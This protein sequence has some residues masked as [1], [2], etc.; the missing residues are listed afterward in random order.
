MVKHDFDWEEFVRCKDV[1]W[2]CADCEQLFC[3]PDSTFYPPLGQE[4]AVS[5]QFKLDI[6]HWHNR[7]FSPGGWFPE[8]CNHTRD[9]GSCKDCWEKKKHEDRDSQKWSVLK[10]WHEKDLMR[11]AGLQAWLIQT[12]LLAH[13]RNLEIV[14][15]EQ[16]FNIE[17]PLF[18]I[19]KEERDAFADD[20]EKSEELIDLTFEALRKKDSKIWNEDSFTWGEV[21]F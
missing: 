10:T 14:L 2:W 4:M 7:F 13:R 9:V 20:R 16:G 21:D 3:Y 17:H 1:R 18:N 15:E 5:Y 19:P 11:W 6:D 8:I 12:P